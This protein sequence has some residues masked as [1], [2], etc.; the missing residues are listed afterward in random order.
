MEQS[1]CDTLTL[2]IEMGEIPKLP[3]LLLMQQLLG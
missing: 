1:M 3:S 2:G